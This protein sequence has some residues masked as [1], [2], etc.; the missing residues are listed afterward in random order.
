MIYRGI[1][2]VGCVKNQEISYLIQKGRCIVFQAY[3]SLQL[4]FQTI[5]QSKQKY[6]DDFHEKVL[7][8]PEAGE[9]NIYLAI[10][11]KCTHSIKKILST[12]KKVLHEQQNF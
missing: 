11:K 10:T 3:V 12:K 6:S 9:H 1:R 4:S 2:L 8:H 5:H 7:S